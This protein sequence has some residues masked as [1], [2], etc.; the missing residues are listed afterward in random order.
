MAD[1]C[2]CLTQLQMQRCR[3]YQARQYETKRKNWETVGLFA[4]VSDCLHLPPMCS[5]SSCRGCLLHFSQSR[6]SSILVCVFVCPPWRRNSCPCVRL[7]VQLNDISQNEDKTRNC[8][9]NLQKCKSGRVTWPAWFGSRRPMRKSTGWGSLLSSIFACTVLG[10]PSKGAGHD[11]GLI[12][13]REQ[14]TQANMLMRARRCLSCSVAHQDSSG[15]NWQETKLW[16][17]NAMCV[18]FTRLW[19][20]AARRQRGWGYFIRHCMKEKNHLRRYSLRSPG[21]TYW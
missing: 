17:P 11:L 1:Q 16:Y 5:C 15:L 4:A 8:C 18:Y 6:P 21:F 20:R 2:Q 14:T 9:R 3:R 19:C 10:R 13:A 7:F 12:W